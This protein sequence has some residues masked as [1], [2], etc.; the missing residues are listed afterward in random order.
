MARDPICGMEVDPATAISAERDGE[1]FYFC[2]P[3][4]RQKF[5][6][7][8]S[9]EQRGDQ[10]DLLQLSGSWQGEKSA[11]P[12][13]HDPGKTG[14]T[15]GGSV[16]PL[17]RDEGDS[18]SYICP[19]CPGV[20]SEVPA[21]C[22]KCGMALESSVPLAPRVSTIYTCPMHPEVEQEGPGQ[23]PK[24]GMDLEPTTIAA[25]DSTDDD[26]LRDMTRRFW[27]STTLALPVLL[28]AMLPMLGVPLDHWLAPEVNRWLQFALATPVVLWCGWP[29]FVRMA[30]S[31]VTWNLNMFTLIG[32][33]TGAA[34]AYS[35]LAMLLPQEIPESFRHDGRA[36]VYFEAAAV[37]IALVLL[38]QVLELRARRRTSGAIRELMSLAPPTARVLRDGQERE[39]PLEQV[40]TG[41]RLRIKPGDKIP[42]D[43]TIDEG[44]STVDESMITGEPLPAERSTGD[45]VIG[46]TVNQT[47][48][49]T[50]IARQVGDQTVLAR[51]VHMVAQAQRSRAPI[52]RLADIVAGWFVPAVVAV[53]VVA[54]F[55]WISFGPP[56]RLAHGLVAAVAVLIVACPCALGLATPMSIM[57]GVGRG[58]HE[59]VL[60]KDAQTLETLEKVD[61]LIVDKTGT[62]TEGRPRVTEVRTVGDMKDEDLLRLAAAVERHSE[63]PLAGAIMTAAIDHGGDLP[64]AD[65]FDSIT[66]SGVSAQ[67]EDRHVLIGKPGLFHEREIGDLADDVTSLQEQGRTVMLIAIDGELAGLVA[68]AD[69]I[70]ESTPTAIEELHAMGITIRMLTGDNEGTARAVAAE[71]GI[72]EV[73]AGVSPEQKHDRVKQLREAGRLVA[74]AGD[75]INDAPALA[76]GAGRHRHGNRYRR[77][78]GER[79]RHAGQGA[80]C[81]ASCGPDKA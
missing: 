1:T 7:G 53:A 3:H 8:A 57:V 47:G 41:D 43:G 59:G 40:Q 14:A 19:M 37:I 69:P 32:L 25:D 21:S 34:Y 71:L 45:E 11:E 49:F 13:C 26:E 68:V 4:C 62:L 65:E 78:D 15:H 2:C 72:D 22:P 61:T 28:L 23:C 29:F 12:S 46:G 48:S 18:G 81:A 77:G 24:C 20:S 58:A 39:V 54:F 74:M 38:G 64:S 36:E 63:H 56:P 44:H 79:R 10:Q 17:A 66:G 6:A 16:Q 33:G 76:A 73:E 60:I 42:V 9:T 67:V 55:A 5:L 80:I 70:K 52:Q 31:L 50:I 35:A 75:G 51:I 30:R 27:V